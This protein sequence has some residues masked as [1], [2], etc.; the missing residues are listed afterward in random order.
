VFLFMCAAIASDVSGQTTAST[1]ATA[2]PKPAPVV[3][4]GQPERHQFDFWIGEWN[5]TT[6]GGTR[7]GSSVIQSVSGGCAILEN[8]TSGGGGQG[9]SLNAYNPD[10]HQWQEYWVG[11]DGG[12]S[13]YRTSEFDGKSLRFFLKDA[14]KP[15]DV[16]RLTFTSVDASTVRQHSE[17]SSDGGQTWTT[18][19]DFYYHRR[20]N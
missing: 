11:Q 5:V 13:D 4:P 16:Q 17:G 3:C 14:A 12:V 20:T 8:W 9:K 15:Q 10:L 7:V 1:A 19:Y 6:Q 2:A 18:I